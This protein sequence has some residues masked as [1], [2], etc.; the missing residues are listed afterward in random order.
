MALNLMEKESIDVKITVHLN[1]E[2]NVLYQGGD[3]FS[4]CCIAVMESLICSYTHTWGSFSQ[5]HN[6]FVEYM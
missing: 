5:N 6:L 1:W 4:Q 3:K 2:I